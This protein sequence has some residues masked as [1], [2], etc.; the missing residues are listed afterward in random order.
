MAE[1]LDYFLANVLTQDTRRR[2]QIH[3]ELLEYI[4]RDESS[5]FCEEMDKFINGLSAWI[6]SSNY[7]ISLNGL[8]IVSCLIDRMGCNF[9]AYIPSLLVSVLDRLGDGKDQVRTSAQDLLIKMMTLGSTP[10]FVFERTTPAFS[11]KSPKV[12]EEILKCLQRLLAEYGSTNV[13]LSKLV[14]HIVKLMD[15]QSIP[16]RDQAIN[17]L[18]VIYQHVGERLRTDLA[19]KEVNPAKLA[20]IFSRLDEVKSSGNMI[21]KECSKSEDELDFCQVV[22]SPL[23][24]KRASLPSVASAAVR[25]SVSTAKLSSASSASATPMKKRHSLAAGKLPSKCSCGLLMHGL[26]WK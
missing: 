9:R 19:K 12:R 24:L 4:Q 13:G 17:T 3:E 11:H 22:G 26:F 8:E 14:P 5:L 7:K 6:S 20:Q 18:V 2:F 10:Q 15:D 16:V 21:S 1:T 23:A 25:T